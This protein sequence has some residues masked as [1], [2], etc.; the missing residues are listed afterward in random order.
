M[1][2]RVSNIL[3]R[4]NNILLRVYKLDLL[5]VN[6]FNYTALGNFMYGKELR[7]VH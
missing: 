6:G 5:D 3:H 1:E 2:S 4:T 7:L